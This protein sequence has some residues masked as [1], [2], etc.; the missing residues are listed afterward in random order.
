MNRES[1]RRAQ[2][3]DLTI[4]RPEVEARRPADQRWRPLLPP[5]ERSHGWPERFGCTLWKSTEPGYF[6]REGPL[7][8]P[9]MVDLT[10]PDPDEIAMVDPVVGRKRGTDPFPDEPGVY[11]VK[12][13]QED[14]TKSYEKFLRLNGDREAH[15]EA[16]DEARHDRFIDDRYLA[17]RCLARSQPAA[18]MLGQC[19]EHATVVR[20]GDHS[21]VTPLLQPRRHE[22][23]RRAIVAF[24]LGQ[25]VVVPRTRKLKPRELKKA[26]ALL[27]GNSTGP[28][29]LSTRKRPL[30]SS[31]NRGAPCVPKTDTEPKVTSSQSEAA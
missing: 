4:T 27:N 22:S 11:A 14:T 5:R 15:R 3:Y 31:H 28:K 25:L 19:I 30:S 29:K 20:R 18:D 1:K 12:V 23:N 7:M 13:L 6:A 26:L 2:D 16:E 9:S 17:E 10:V 21:A 24:D 8:R